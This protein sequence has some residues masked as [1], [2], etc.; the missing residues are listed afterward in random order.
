MTFEEVE[1]PHGDNHDLWINPDNPLIMV[2]GNERKGSGL[3]HQPMLT[4]Q[5]AWLNSIVASADAKPTDQ[6]YARFRDLESELASQLY[7]V[8]NVLETDLAQF[9]RMVRD[10]GVP[11]IVVPAAARQVAAPGARQR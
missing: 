2:E 11:P 5:L 4:D 1:T 10:R 8:P 9:N 7:A 6:S 3:A